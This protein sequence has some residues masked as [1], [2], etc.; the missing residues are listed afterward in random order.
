MTTEFTY[1]DP[2][3]NLEWEMEYK[4]GG[5]HLNCDEVSDT[6]QNVVLDVSYFT[7]EYIESIVKAANEYIE[8]KLADDHEERG[9]FLYHQQKEEWGDEA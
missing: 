7:D 8:V 9:D 6:Y 1:T 2:N 5:T 3:T 4:D